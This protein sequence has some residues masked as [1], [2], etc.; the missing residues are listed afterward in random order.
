MASGKF[1]YTRVQQGTDSLPCQE[2]RCYLFCQLM[3]IDEWVS[4]DYQLKGQ[5]EKGGV[6]DGLRLK[7]KLLLFS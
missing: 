7:S 1:E 2:T 3:A 6:T 5:V 4:C